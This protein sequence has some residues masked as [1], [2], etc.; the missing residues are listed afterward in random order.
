MLQPPD[1]VRGGNADLAGNAVRLEP[2]QHVAPEQN[3]HIEFDFVIE[4]ACLAEQ[5]ALD[6]PFPFGEP[7]RDAVLR[8]PAIE[9][10][11]G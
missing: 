8:E 7:R 5:C 1:L 3:V 10:N 11:E 9:L 4:P 6:R 2:L